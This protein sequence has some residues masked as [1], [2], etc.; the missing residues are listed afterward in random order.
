MADS[1][2]YWLSYAQEKFNGVLIVKGDSFLDAAIEAHR[3]GLSPGGQVA[4]IPIPLDKLDNFPAEFRNR[5]LTKEEAK[6]FK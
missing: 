1:G 6:S 3:L 4:G 2:W 5:L